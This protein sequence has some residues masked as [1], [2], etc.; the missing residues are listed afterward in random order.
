MMNAL[1][2]LAVILLLVLIAGGV[3]YAYLYRFLFKTAH[4]N[5]Q[6]F[7]RNAN[8]TG[9][10]RILFAGD[11]LTCGNMSADYT[12][13]VADK[14][15]EN[16]EYINAGVNADLAYNLWQRLDEII[17]C[18]PE[19]V[20]ILIGTNDANATLFKENQ[21]VYQKLKKLP[22]PATIFWYEENLCKIIERLQNETPAQI[23]L[24]SMPVLGENLK[25]KANAHIR[26]YVEVVKKVA[27]KYQVDYVPFYE[28]HVEF[29][30]QKPGIR[31]QYHPNHKLIELAMFQRYILR[32]TWD[33]IAQ[34]HGFHTVTDFIHL[35]SV[36]AKIL[37]DLICEWIEGKT[38][39]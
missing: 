17:A 15:G 12:K 3:I 6:N 24:V 19:W 14:L 2:L 9:K 36:G 20:S 11:S 18:Q 22:Q 32:R 39:F 35:N 37:A 23:A 38:K 26:E 7:L 29:L 16:Y 28:K 34:T 30:E 33:E 13:M 1:L 25:H 27:Q 5:P 4:N 21:A 31:K 10:K 8:Q